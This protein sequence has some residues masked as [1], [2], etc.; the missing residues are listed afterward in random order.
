MSPVRVAAPFPDLAHRQPP[1]R[2]RRGPAT[3]NVGPAG[4]DIPYRLV[5]GVAEVEPRHLAPEGRVGGTDERRQA[6]TQ[7]GQLPVVES[8]PIPVHHLPSRQQGNTVGMD[9]A[10]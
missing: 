5:D 3:K 7:C 4:R 10:R 6:L 8:K 1:A 2:S 9:S